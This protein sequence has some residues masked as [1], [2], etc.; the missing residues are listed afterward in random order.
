MKS[1]SAVSPTYRDHIWQRYL[2]RLYLCSILYPLLSLV[3]SCAAGT[4]NTQITEIVDGWIHLDF[5][6]PRNH[7]GVLVDLGLHKWWWLDE[8]VRG[9]DPNMAAPCHYE[10][11]GTRL[12]LTLIRQRGDSRSGGEIRFEIDG[13]L[14][15]RRD[16]E[17]FGP[18]EGK[19]YWSS[20]TWGYNSIS[21]APY[22][23]D[24]IPPQDR[25]GNFTGYC[26]W[27]GQPVASLRIRK[28]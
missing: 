23:R 9:R 14:S 28:R 5:S 11:K 4:T 8:E 26:E 19:V 6:F 3:S 24:L 17:I 16:Q 12:K 27:E 18:I 13:Q 2:K 22:E 10:L 25:R 1:S 21:G 7:F 20:L 15:D